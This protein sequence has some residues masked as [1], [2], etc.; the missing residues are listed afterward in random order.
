MAHRAEAHV[1]DDGTVTVKDQ[2]FPPG[3]E[4]EVIVL[5]R[6]KALEGQYSLRGTPYRFDDPFS[7]VAADEW[8]AA[9]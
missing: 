6:G 2:P 3:T 9:G 5:P 8:E 7:P 4:V 1:G